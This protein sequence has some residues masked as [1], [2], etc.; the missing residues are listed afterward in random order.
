MISDITY[1]RRGEPAIGLV[2]VGTTWSEIDDQLRAS[3]EPLLVL[4]P[5]GGQYQGFYWAGRTVPT[6]GLGPDRNTAAQRFRDLLNSPEGH[7]QTPADEVPP[8]SG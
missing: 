8:P 5:E 4:L 6:P 3:R 2:P 1:D 7:G